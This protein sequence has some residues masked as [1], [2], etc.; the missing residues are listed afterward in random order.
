MSMISFIINISFG[1]HVYSVSILS[2]QD[3]RICDKIK[4]TLMI[5]CEK[6]HTN[7]A[8][9][10]SMLSLSGQPFTEDKHRSQPP[11]PVHR[12]LGLPVNKIKNVKAS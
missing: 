8:D 6:E 7:Q 1:H 3:C 10:L 2:V 5:H 4:A 12:A 11:S 9:M